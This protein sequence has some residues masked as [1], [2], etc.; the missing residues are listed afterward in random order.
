[1]RTKVVEK[2][3]SKTPIEIEQ[4]IIQLYNNGI[5]SMALSRN[6]NLSH[7]TIYNILKRNKIPFRK[8]QAPI[9]NTY[10]I[11]F[12]DTY[13]KESC[14][15]AGFISAD[16]NIN[17]NCNGVRIELALKDK[18]H[19]LKLADIVNFQG[20]ILEHTRIRNQKEE[21]SCSINF[22]GTW[23]KDSLQEYFDI[24]P[25]K[26]FS[27]NISPKIPSEYILDYIRGYFD[28]DGSVFLNKN[29]IV[30]KFTS[31]SKDLINFFTDYFYAKGI[32]VRKNIKNITEKPQIDNMSIRY[33]GKNAIK[34]LHWM[35]D[36]TT[37]NIR[38]SRKYEIFTNY[39]KEI[40]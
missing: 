19:L 38:L 12:F 39:L 32:R 17:K 2:E 8:C 20:E 35:Y 22:F 25:Q 3:M 5:G 26:T 13:T 40:N 14:Y 36:N 29:K 6:F 33:Y 7:T 4:E 24:G 28:G 10:N 30:V 15:W 21:K 11:H 31:G 1:M 9:K 23:F 18:E 34:I 27:T 37:E 16:G